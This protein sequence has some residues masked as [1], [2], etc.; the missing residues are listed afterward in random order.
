MIRTTSLQLSIAYSRELP[1][2]F[3]HSLACLY[4]STTLVSCQL[5][6]F[7]SGRD[8]LFLKCFSKQHR[9][10]IRF[11]FVVIEIRLHAML[12]ENVVRKVIA[13]VDQSV[14]PV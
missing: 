4:V 9:F 5:W 10:V 8:E 14:E 12:F 13:F 11:K 3:I 1:G 7:K 2:F 6:H